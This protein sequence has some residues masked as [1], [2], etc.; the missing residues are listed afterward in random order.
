MQC[1]AAAV[2][3]SNILQRPLYGC[4]LLDPEIK[5]S[6]IHGQYVQHFYHQLNITNPGHLSTTGRD[7][8]IDICG[9]KKEE[10]KTEVSTV[11]SVSLEHTGH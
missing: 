4:G 11:S 9:M 3:D 7:S 10:M 5:M 1:P 6:L 2:R 8:S